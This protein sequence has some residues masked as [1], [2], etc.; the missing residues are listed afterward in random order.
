MSTALAT[1]NAPVVKMGAL[2]PPAS[3]RDPQTVRPE[4]LAAY[5]KQLEQACLAEPRSASLRT[6]LGMAYAVNYEVEKSMDALEAAVALEPD[7]FWAQLKY[8]ELLYRL[9]ILNRAEEGTL[10]A[11]TLANDPWQLSAARSQLRS[12]RTLK[13]SCVR[14][15]EWS[16]PL[17]LPALSLAAMM[18]LIF[19]VMMWR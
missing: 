19:V 12:I 11:L 9:R 15:V 13:H 6:C 4:D 1:I 17:M 3:W 14:N 7:N 8:A 10:T 16:K 2:P 5:I 18:L